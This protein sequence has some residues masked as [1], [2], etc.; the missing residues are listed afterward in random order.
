MF[1][2][3]LGTRFTEENSNNPN[4]VEFNCTL[5][6]NIGYADDT[7]RLAEDQDIATSNDRKSECLGNQTFQ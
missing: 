6:E 4:G 7:V 1:T 2:L 5:V 3:Y